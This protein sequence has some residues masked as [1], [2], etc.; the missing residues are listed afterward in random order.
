[1]SEESEFESKVN[2][3]ENTFNKTEANDKKN[4]TSKEDVDSKPKI[5]LLKEPIES[6][7][8]IL[9]VPELS[10]DQLNESINKY[11]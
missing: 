5:I 3:T 2:E 9:T 6:Q 1:M 10:G 11:V 8:H 4:N 7:V